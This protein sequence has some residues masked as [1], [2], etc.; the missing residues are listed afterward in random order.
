M[1]LAGSVAFA[2]AFCVAGCSGKKETPSGGAEAQKP[3]PSTEAAAAPTPDTRRVDTT[4]FR[5][6]R[7]LAEDG[8]AKG[9]GG[10]F[11]QGEKLYVSF[12]VLRAPAGSAVKILVTGLTDTRK[13]YEEQKSAAAP[14]STMSFSLPDTRSW[15][16]GGYLLEMLFLDGADVQRGT[17]NFKII[18]P[19]R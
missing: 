13:F 8:T 7:E 10:P 14:G 17:F 12:K 2:L 9:E 16:T 6:G 4:E 5:F 15:P 1:R 19:K 18:P 3:R 11:A